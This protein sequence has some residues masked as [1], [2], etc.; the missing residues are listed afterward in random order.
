MRKDFERCYVTAHGSVVV[1]TMNHPEVM[2]AASVKMIHGM[3]AAIDYI[4]KP[5][6]GFRAIVLTGEGR[7]FCSGANL[8][9]V[10]EEGAS[11]GGV[12]SA[13]ETSYHLFLRRLRDLKMPLV[14]AVNGAAAGVGM[15]IALMGEITAAGGRI[16]QSNFD[17]YPVAR[18]NQAPFETHVHIVTNDAAP[19]GVGEP[20]VPPIAPAICNAVFAATGKRIRE[21][22]IKGQLS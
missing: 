2:N 17:R 15:S 16:Q 22:P 20:G 5:D 13:L 4:E 10:P 1:L 19:A 18:M 6:S 9:E 14:T 7:G 8:S 3:I 12:G 21:L 11:S